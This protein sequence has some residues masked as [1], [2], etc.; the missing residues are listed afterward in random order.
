MSVRGY[1]LLA[2]WSRHGT[3]ANVLE[4]LTSHIADN[5]DIFV[6]YGRDQSQATTVA[7]A[8][9]LTFALNNP[10][11]FFSSENPSSPITGNVVPGTPVKLLKTHQLATRTLFSGVLDNFDVDPQ[12]AAKTFTAE[13]L[14]ATVRGAEPLSTELYSGLRTGDAIGLI[15]D[16]IAWSGDRDLD[17]GATVMPWWWEEGTDPVEAIEKL[18]ASEGPPAIAYVHGG[19]FVFRDRHHR[20]LRPASQT[21]QATFTH[22]IPAGS[23]P[24]GSFM[25]RSDSFSYDHGLRHIVN[26]V[27]FSVGQ[28]EPGD[29]TE[30]WSTDTPITFADGQTKTI[31]IETND[32]FFN[33]MT[34]AAGVDY[35]VTGVVSVSLSRTSGQAATLTITASGGPAIITRLA[36]RAVSVP[37]VRTIDVSV[38]DT[39]SIS[40]HTTQPWPGQ[41]PPFAN[42]YDAEAIARR[43]IATYATNRPVVTFQITNLDDDYMTQIL[44]RRVSDRIR[45]I[46]DS[47]SLDAEFIIERITHSIRKLGVI[48]S[49]EF[50]C[51]VVD[52]TQS[53]NIFTFDVAGK[54]FDDGAF[55]I[56]GIDNADN[57]LMFDVAGRG[58]DDGVFAT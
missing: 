53:E 47:I 22:A 21:S 29:I 45:V 10:D 1:E 28:R 9:K 15:L 37:V 5:P 42:V 57:T 58:F 35:D 46:N 49:V 32:P 23:G 39:A 3:F 6:S 56:D 17:P 48:H 11:Q 41:V 7:T 16:A 19:T 38:E 50:G 43:I 44:D 4:D 14:D 20:L 40:K 25:I 24:V 18:V 2:D 31:I 33:A 27:N 8:G 12:A 36:L 55:G 52:P 54:G 34:P 13:V 51:Q 26:T 30:V